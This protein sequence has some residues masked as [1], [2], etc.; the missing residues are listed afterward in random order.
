LAATLSQAVTDIPGL[1]HGHDRTGMI[2]VNNSGGDFIKQ[3]QLLKVA[4][5]M[6]GRSKPSPLHYIVLTR[7]ES[8]WQYQGFPSLNGWIFYNS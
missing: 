6:L 8:F 1:L 3:H 2:F 7:V 5:Y 4:H